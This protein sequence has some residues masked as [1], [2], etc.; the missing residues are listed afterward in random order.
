MTAPAFLGKIAVVTG[1][2]SGIGRELAVQLVARGARLALSDLDATSLATTIV[3]CG[4]IEAR[5]Y[6]L[7]V[8]DREAVLTH[9]ADVEHDPGAMNFV[10]NNA[11]ATRTGSFEH[12]SREEIDSQSGIYLWSFMYRSN[13]FLTLMLRQREGCIVNISPASSTSLAFPPA[14]TAP[15]ASSEY[16]P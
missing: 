8:A 15:S 14:A 12:A 9:A 16:E 7:D 4:A 6:A 13:A 10:F 11:G 5:G 1:A 2:G 3:L